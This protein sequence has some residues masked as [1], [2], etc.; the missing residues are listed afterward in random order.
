MTDDL[1]N[2]RGTVMWLADE[3]RLGHWSHLAHGDGGA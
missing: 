3:R 2:L 1:S